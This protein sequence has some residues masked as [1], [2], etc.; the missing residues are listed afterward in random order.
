MDSSSNGHELYGK[1]PL[2]VARDKRLSD[3]AVRLYAVLAAHSD[4]RSG[5]CWMRRSRLSEEMG[6]GRGQISALLLR[7]EEAGWIEIER[8]PGHMSQYRV[9]ST[10]GGGSQLDRQGVSVQPATSSQSSRQSSIREQNSTQQTGT[11]ARARDAEGEEKDGPAR[12]D[13]GRD[14]GAGGS[15]LA[16][17]LYVIRSD[18]TATLRD[19]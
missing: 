12:I 5:M 3:G 16:R 2:A 9:V 14:P 13:A 17:G 6:R 15:N 8:V 1:V 11:R 7:L 4:K 18:G 10:A 19:V